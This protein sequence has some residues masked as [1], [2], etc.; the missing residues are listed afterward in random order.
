MECCSA[1]RFGIQL[2]EEQILARNNYTA[3]N[4]QLLEE[5]PIVTE[6]GYNIFRRCLSSFVYAR[7]LFVGR[8]FKQLLDLTEVQISTSFPVSNV[9]PMSLSPLNICAVHRNRQPPGRH[10]RRFQRR[11]LQSGRTAVECH[12]LVQGLPF[13]RRCWRRRRRQRFSQNEPAAQ[14]VDRER[15]NLERSPWRRIGE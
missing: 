5:L 2:E 11:P 8:T 4:S 6:H 14:I 9:F 10:R 3:L 15:S 7:K 13:I 1:L 12:F